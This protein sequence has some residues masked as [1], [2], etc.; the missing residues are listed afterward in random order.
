MRSI[1]LNG[2]R[3][4]SAEIRIS[5]HADT[6][7]SLKIYQKPTDSDQHYESFY[8]QKNPLEAT[9]RIQFSKA[10]EGLKEFGLNQQSRILDIGCGKGQFLDQVEESTG[11][12]AVG[13]EPAVSSDKRIV[14]A[15]LEEAKKHFEV[16]SFDFVTL[17]DVFEHLPNPDSSLIE[18][19]SLLKPGGYLLL[20]VPNK[21][22]LLYRCALQFSRLPPKA[23]WHKLLS[24][25]YQ[26]EYPPPHYFYYS[27]ESLRK[28][29]SPYL[30]VK[31][32]FY[33]SEIY[34]SAF[35]AR[36]WDV[37]NFFKPF[38]LF[39][40]FVYKMIAIGSLKDSYVVIARKE[41]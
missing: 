26:I 22:S 29:I 36:L 17:F 38:F 18:L 33:L 5:A 4:C 3:G 1:A 11:A 31:K 10:I 15:T 14:N 28:I 12:S 32:D 8:Q 7:D 23:F 19:K 25:I 37:R 16:E 13:L 34:L 41:P 30:R 20:K 27:R 24:R 35:L 2:P 6:P 40:A 21:K 9:R 39:C